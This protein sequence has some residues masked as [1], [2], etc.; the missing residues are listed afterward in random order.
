MTRP[1]NAYSN[2]EGE[3]CCQYIRSLPDDRLGWLISNPILSQ[4]LLD[5]A[6]FCDECG[7]RIEGISRQQAESLQAEIKAAC[8]R[9]AA[10]PIAHNVVTGKIFGIAASAARFDRRVFPLAASTENAARCAEEVVLFGRCNIVGQDFAFLEEQADGRVFLRG[11]IPSG[12]THLQLGSRLICLKEANSDEER[13]LEGL[14]S[15]EVERFLKS[16][17]NLSASFVVQHLPANE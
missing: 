10:A 16:A 3:G 15:L 2:N 14:S 13:E 6:A 1:N 5:H 11:P 7:R 8:D 4:D 9:M 17:E 12:A